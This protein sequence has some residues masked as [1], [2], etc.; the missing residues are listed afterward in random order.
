MQKPIE[1]LEQSYLRTKARNYKAYAKTMELQANS[2]NNT[3]FADAD[4][5]IAYW[6]GNFIPRRDQ[7]STS[8]SPSTAAIPRPTGTACSPSKK[9]PTCST[10]PAAISTTRTTG[11]GRAQARAA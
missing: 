3:I 5:D 1:A 2:S 7:T 11:R 9:R 4:G 10:P 6:H 8:P